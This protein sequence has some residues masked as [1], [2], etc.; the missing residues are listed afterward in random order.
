MKKYSIQRKEDY[1]LITSIDVGYVDKGFYT[2]GYQTI[3]GVKTFKN[4][5]KRVLAFFYLYEI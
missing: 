3:C 1:Q 2:T 4:R 5:K